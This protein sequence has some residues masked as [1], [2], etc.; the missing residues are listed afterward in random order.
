MTRY[1][2]C[3]MFTL[4]FFGGDGSIFVEFVGTLHPRI[5]ILNVTISLIENFNDRMNGMKHSL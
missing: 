4:N 3:R 5:Y 1:V 2:I